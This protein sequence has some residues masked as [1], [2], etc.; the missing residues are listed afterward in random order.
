M[1][2]GEAMSAA[3]GVGCN[4]QATVAAIVALVREAGARAACE[5]SSLHTAREVRSPAL[6]AAAVELGLTLTRHDL[7]ALAATRDGVVSHS[8]RVEALFGVGSLAEAA[9]LAGA[10]QGAHLIVPKFSADGVSCAA[11]ST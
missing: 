1:A 8:E 11:A 10:G 7:D 5:I 4:S 6:D 2:G 9:A 3:V